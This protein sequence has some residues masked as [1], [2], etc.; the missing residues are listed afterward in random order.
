MVRNHG[1]RQV[2]IGGAYV[3]LLLVTGKRMV[4]ETRAG[5]GAEQN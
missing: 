4:G 3:R 2:L 5:I 1:L